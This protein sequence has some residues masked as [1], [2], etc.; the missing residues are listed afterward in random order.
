MTVLSYS[1]N[2]RYFSAW[3]TFMFRIPSKGYHVDILQGAIQV[4]PISQ[5]MRIHHL[6]QTQTTYF[7]LTRLTPEVIRNY[8][9]M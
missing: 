4:Y 5:S 2:A 7:K 6:P 8:F 1:N 9:K 3:R